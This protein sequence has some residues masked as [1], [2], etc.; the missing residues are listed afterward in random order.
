MY[1]TA[2]DVKDYY[3]QLKQNVKEVREITDYEPEIA[4][5]LGSGLGHFADNLDIKAE[6]DLSK[7]SNFPQSTVVGHKGSL[8]FGELCNMKC[9]V[10][11]GRVHYY[12]GYDVSEVVKPIRLMHMLGADKAIFTCSC[13]AVNPY[14]HQGDIVIIRDHISFFVPSP[15]LGP[16]I[17]EFGVRFPDLT[18]PYCPA[19]RNYAF[20]AARAFD[21]DLKDG[22]FAQ[23]TGPAYETA[24]ESRVLYG[25][26]VDV[27]SM[28]TSVEVIAARHMDMRVAHVALVTNM[29]T[30]LQN[31]ELSHQ[32]VMELSKK[33][34]N[35]FTNILKGIVSGLHIEK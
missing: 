19:M 1:K 25:Y 4:I 5:V 35:D 11:N 17:E 34:A 28:S 30:G 27:V 13:G 2:Q 3:N 24:S 6:I 33:R 23:T 20:D 21:I 32:E 12:E 10:L 26:G 31:N 7:L 18:E 8:I 16:N 29:T 15:L 14:L 22:V 9:V